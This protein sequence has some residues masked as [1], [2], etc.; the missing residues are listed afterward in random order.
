MNRQ[1]MIPIGLER[2]EIER[3][4]QRFERLFSALQESIEADA[5]ET[6][7]TF[8]PPVDICEAEH[9]IY[10]YL[11]LAGVSPEEINLTIN[12]GELLI[13]GIKPASRRTQKKAVSHFCCERQ[14]GKFRRRIK[15]RWAIDL[16][17]TSATLENGM[18][19]VYLPK[20]ADRRGKTV[21]IEIENLGN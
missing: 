5:L 4:R 1:K 19:E 7:G 9:G 16:N 8:L 2:A 17:E 10:I 12:A 6:Y 15:L 13:E 21:K 3:L 11:E 18:L 14:Y 20:I